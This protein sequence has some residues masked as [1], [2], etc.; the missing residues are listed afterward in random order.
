MEDRII[1]VDDG[2]TGA[3]VAAAL[4]AVAGVPEVLSGMKLGNVLDVKDQLIAIRKNL[5]AEAKRADQVVPAEFRTIMLSKSKALRYIDVKIILPRRKQ[6]RH[7]FICRPGQAFNGKMV[8]DQLDKVAGWLEQTYPGIDFRLVEVGLGTFN[9]IHPA[10]E[11]RPDVKTSSSDRQGIGTDGD[12]GDNRVGPVGAIGDGVDE[13]RLDA[14][15]DRVDESIVDAEAT[16]GAQGDNLQVDAGVP[17][18]AVSVADRALAASALAQRDG[19]P[20]HAGIVTAP[21]EV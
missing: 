20:E 17:V 8:S 2:K 19:M 6:K 3:A 9:I 1:V 7:R 14:D 11:K 12:S 15:A 5:Q 21:K 18:E 10:A 16:A 4:T 13:V